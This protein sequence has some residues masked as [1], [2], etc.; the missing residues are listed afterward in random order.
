[1][2]TRETAEQIT[3]E[4]AKICGC[5]WESCT[6]VRT[7]TAEAIDAAL[8]QAIADER[9]RCARIAETE[10][11]HRSKNADF[12]RGYAFAGHSVAAAIRRKDNNDE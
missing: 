3:A 6:S 12:Q 2:N 7:A 9:E 8:Q 5:N 11:N 1:M 10:T 4:V